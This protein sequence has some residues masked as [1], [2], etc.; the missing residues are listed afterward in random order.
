MRHK[1]AKMSNSY[2]Q[3]KIMNPRESPRDQR[4]AK[5]HQ[6]HYSSGSDG[7]HYNL[8]DKKDEGK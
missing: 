2:L 5:T 3:S 7:K 1:F 8:V 6:T 4:V